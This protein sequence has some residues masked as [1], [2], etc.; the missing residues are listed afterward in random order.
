MLCC[1]VIQ[2]GL[3]RG[4]ES[5][6]VVATF[7]PVKQGLH[8]ARAAL[9]LL[10]AAA[11]SL[12]GAG[13]LAAPSSAAFGSPSVVHVTPT[14]IE[15]GQAAATELDAAEEQQQQPDATG[16]FAADS[17]GTG[18]GSSNRLACEK[19][20]LTIVG[21]AK[22]GALSIEPPSLA[23]GSISVGYPQRKALKLINQSAGVLR[24]HVTVE[25]ENPAGVDP[26]E[27]PCNF[28]SGAAV[29]TRAA[30]AGGAADCWLDAPEGLVNAR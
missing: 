19:L 26:S 3:L 16:A 13:P 7:S 28:G 10:P 30:D 17:T 11:A 9:L 2:G 1:D 22:Q 23:F 27:V 21:E 24:Y 29:L 15:Y 18:S 14:A 12:R 4:Y 6:K 20:I 5:V 25:D 8:N